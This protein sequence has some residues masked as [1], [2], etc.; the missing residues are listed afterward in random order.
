MAR[1]NEPF[2]RRS[3]LRHRHRDVAP[4]PVVDNAILHG[5]AHQTVGPSITRTSNEPTTRVVKAMVVPGSSPGRH[6]RAHVCKTFAAFPA[7]N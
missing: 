6:Y 5:D 1:S 7:M 3:R 2:P 4:A